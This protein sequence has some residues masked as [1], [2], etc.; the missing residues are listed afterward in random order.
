M[1]AN[2]EMVSEKLKKTTFPKK[3]NAILSFKSYIVKSSVW[4]VTNKCW[5]KC[6]KENIFKYTT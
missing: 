3:N 1:I 6:L 5:T 4:I 2:K